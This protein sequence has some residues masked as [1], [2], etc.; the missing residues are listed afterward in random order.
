MHVPLKR[1]F[2]EKCCN[3]G[4]NHIEI[5]RGCL[6]NNDLKSKLSLG[7]QACRNEMPNSPIVEIT[8]RSLKPGIVKNNVVQGS[9]AKA[10]KGNPGQIQ[11]AQ[12]QMLQKFLRQK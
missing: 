3:C 11:L 10:A 4:G 1:E 8:D 6:V 7:I 9:Y 2:N 12:N 5:Y